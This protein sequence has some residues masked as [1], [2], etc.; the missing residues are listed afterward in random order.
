MKLHCVP[1]PRY[2]IVFSLVCFK[3]VTLPRKQMQGLNSD[4]AVYECSV[5]VGIYTKIRKHNTKRI[6]KTHIEDC[7]LWTDDGTVNG[8]TPDNIF[9]H[10]KPYQEMSLMQLRKVQIVLYHCKSCSLARFCF[11]NYCNCFDT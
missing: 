8:N 11:K 5:C 6:I 4:S 10:F 3:V 9:E 7:T 2:F 1:L